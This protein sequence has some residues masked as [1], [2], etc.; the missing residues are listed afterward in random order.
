V[1]VVVESKVLQ[2]IL[3]GEGGENAVL[4]LRLDGQEGKRRHVM[5]RDLQSDPVDGGLV[6][7][8]FLRIDME[9]K[10]NVDVQLE[11]VGVANGVKN[12]GGFMDFVVREVEL[13]CR[14]GDI[15][16]HLEIDVSEMNMGDVFRAGDLDLG[17]NVDL[18]TDPAQALV[19]ISGRGAEEEEA[20][21]AEGEEAAPEAAEGAAPKE[22]AAEDE[23]KD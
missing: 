16:G 10:V 12:E 20:A 8:D 11:T 22:E 5:I 6:H 7:V 3:A 14:P 18:L 23:K 2:G 13:S 15:P 17:P 9:Q 21:A 1:P 4:H 19:V